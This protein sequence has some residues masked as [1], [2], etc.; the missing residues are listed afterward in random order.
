MASQCLPDLNE[1]LGV[2]VL[3]HDFDQR[4]HGGHVLLDAVS[5]PGGR[6]D[7]GDE[8]RGG[9][10]VPDLRLHVAAV[11]PLG[12]PTEDCVGER[13]M[14]GLVLHQRLTDSLQRLSLP[15]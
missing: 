4:D 12:D 13:E 6:F 9:E 8:L 5:F 10:A 1:S 14:G 11:E 3:P 2:D 15:M 7:G